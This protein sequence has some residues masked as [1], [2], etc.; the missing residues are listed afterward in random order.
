MAPTNE[1]RQ[2]YAEVCGP[3]FKAII[4]MMARKEE[5]I[6]IRTAVK[7]IHEKLFVGNGQKS[8]VTRVEIL[9][10]QGKFKEQTEN[11]QINWKKW[12][13]TVVAGIIIFVSQIVILDWLASRSH[14]Q[15]QQQA[16]INK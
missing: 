12:A 3:Q 11:R 13:A 9:E 8:L 6:E 7:Q 10:Q 1:E 2:Q 16:Q 4:D 15:Q 14:I 5:Q